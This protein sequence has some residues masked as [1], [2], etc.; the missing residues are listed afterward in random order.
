MYVRHINQWYALYRPLIRYCA[1]ALRFE[2]CS[3]LLPALILNFLFCKAYYI[4]KNRIMN[5]H[6]LIYVQLQLSLFRNEL[7]SQYLEREI[8]CGQSLC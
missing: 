4:I 5:F 2:Q 1:V 6:D 3:P 7:V 8:S